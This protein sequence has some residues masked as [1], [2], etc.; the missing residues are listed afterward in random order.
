MGESSYNKN[1]GQRNFRGEKKRL[2]KRKKK[3][4]KCKRFGH[5]ARECNANKK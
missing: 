5:F 4:H 1:G 2:D 3:C